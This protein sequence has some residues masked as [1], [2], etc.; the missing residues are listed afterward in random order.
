MNSHEIHKPSVVPGETYERIV[1][2]FDPSIANIFSSFDL[3]LLECF[4]NRPKG[5]YNKLNL[6]NE[7]INQVLSLLYKI[8]NLS[9]ISYKGSD[10]LKLLNF[11]QT[12]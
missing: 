5:K 1:I 6:N 8:E 2:H 4:I 11:I 9:K 10:I 7:Q 3:N 12:L